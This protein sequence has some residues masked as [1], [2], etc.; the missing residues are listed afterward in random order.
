MGD[1]LCGWRGDAES[2]WGA[3]LSKLIL[4]AETYSSI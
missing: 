2:R 3:I 1:A 4:C